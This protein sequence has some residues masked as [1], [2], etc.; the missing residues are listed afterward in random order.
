[1]S[2]PLPAPKG[3]SGNLGLL[4]SERANESR[5]AIIDLRDEKKTKVITY[6]KLEAMCN[7]VARGLTKRGLKQGDRIGILSLN[8]AEYISTLLGAMRAGV[9]PVPLNIKLPSNTISYIINDANIQLIFAENAFCNKIPF[10]IEL[11]D[12]D[13]QFS[14]FLN[15]GTYEA[16]EPKPDSIAIQPY[17]SG[18]TGRPKGVLLTHYGQNWSRRILAHTRGTTEKDVILVAAPLYH[19]NA[20]NAVKQGLTAGAT[21]PLLPQF[22]VERYIKAIGKYHCT[23]IS[24]VPTMISMILN[25]ELLERTDT[26]SVRTVMMGS[27]PSSPQLLSS[28]KVQFPQASALVVYG[29]TEGGPVPLGPHPEGKERPLGS[30]GAPYHGTAAKLVGGNSPEEGELAVKN[31]GILAEYH[32]LPN[33]TQNCIKDGWYLTGDICRRD[34]DGFYFFLS[35]TDDMFVCGGENIYPVEV[36]KILEQHPKVHQVLVLP[37]EHELK[38]HVPYAFIVPRENEQIAE[39][40]IKKFSLEKGPAYMHPRRVFFLSILPLTG[41]NKI[42]HELIRTWVLEDKLTIN[43]KN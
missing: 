34:K 27:A 6:K 18:S 40:E 23:V 43:T 42:D 7:G 21:L 19:K 9:I 36:E 11:I 35:R 12:F 8:R 24:G 15:F 5:P 30:I 26:N 16:F 32:N 41:T 1:M 20:L 38:G 29:V 3:Y 33:E 25:S 2:V 4:F 17:T 28:V 10:G 39:D 37:F 14:K 31:P 22:S 13:T